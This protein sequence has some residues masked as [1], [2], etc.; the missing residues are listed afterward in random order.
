MRRCKEEVAVG[1]FGGCLIWTFILINVDSTRLYLLAPK[2]AKQTQQ[3]HNS[4]YLL[5]NSIK[6]LVRGQL[7]MENDRVVALI[8][9][10][11]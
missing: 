8:Y 7:N 3:L 1:A 10:K 11:Y 6:A 4:S 5:R 9:S 2:S